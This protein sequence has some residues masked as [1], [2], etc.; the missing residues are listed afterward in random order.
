MAVAAP[1]STEQR[2]ELGSERNIAVF[3]ALAVL[4]VDQH[5]GT[6]DLRDAQVDRFV[7]A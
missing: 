2:Q 7:E 6:V 4:D 1:V 5:A 3:A